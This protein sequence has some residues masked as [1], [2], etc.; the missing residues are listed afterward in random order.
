MMGAGKMSA[1]GKMSAGLEMSAAEMAA[2]EVA[3][4]KMAASEMAAAPAMTSAAV[5]AATVSAA[6]PPRKCAA[7]KDD[8]K[9]GDCHDKPGHWH[10]S[11]EFSAGEVTRDGTESSREPFY[12]G[13]IS[14]QTRSAFVAR[15]NRFTLFPHPEEREARLEG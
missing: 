1:T 5:S 13:M 8:R 4:A 12:L 7:G 10:P 2:T 11:A 14:A 15:E 6:A 3:T 9:H